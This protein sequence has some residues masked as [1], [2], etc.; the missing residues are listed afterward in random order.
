MKILIKN[1]CK[2][3]YRPNP[4]ITISKIVDKIP[5][6]FLEGL[7]AIEIFDHGKKEYPTARYIKASN[8]SKQGKIEL[9]MDSRSLSGIPFLSILEQNIHIINAINNHVEFYVK[10]KTN[11]QQ[12]VNYTTNKINLS[13]IHIGPWQPLVVI[14]RLTSF[15]IGKISFLYKLY[16]RMVNFILKKTKSSAGQ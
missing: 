2:K 1:N 15:M 7:S 10:P 5:S 14:F 9:Y 16:S 13:W 3:K 6:S 8:S 12:T 11:D 4:E